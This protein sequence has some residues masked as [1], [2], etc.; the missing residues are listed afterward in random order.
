MSDLK[1]I[2]RTALVSLIICVSSLFHYAIRVDA[3][4]LCFASMVA[5]VLLV[6]CF[7]MLPGALFTF[8]WNLER[9]TLDDTKYLRSLSENKPN[10][11]SQSPESIP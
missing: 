5:L 11:E 3:I 7:F 9:G 1:L 8:Q 10:G 4:I 2:L 6:M